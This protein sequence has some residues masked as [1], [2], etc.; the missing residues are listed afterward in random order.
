MII[1]LL[2][3]KK[4]IKILNKWNKKILF[5]T[6]VL[7]K[8]TQ[9]KKIYSNTRI[10]I[11]LNPRSKQTVSK[12]YLKILKILYFILYITNQF[13][14]EKKED[15]N[16]TFLILMPYKKINLIFLKSEFNLKLILL[17]LES[18]FKQWNQKIIKK[19]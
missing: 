12:K 8:M 10:T 1:K 2:K 3:K 6:K 17:F 14:K 11:M 16:F 4:M 13:S 15:L 9:M 7:E 19:R 18:C 5:S